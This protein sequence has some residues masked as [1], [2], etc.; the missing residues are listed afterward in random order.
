MKIPNPLNSKL[1][2]SFFADVAPYFTPTL[3]SM[4]GLILY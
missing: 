1:E 2:P 3:L 4:F